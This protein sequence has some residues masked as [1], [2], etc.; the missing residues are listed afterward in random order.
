[1]IGQTF[2]APVALALA[3]AIACTSPRETEARREFVRSFVMSV[4]EGSEFYR[5]HLLQAH[6]LE[7]EKARFQMSSSFEIVHEDVTSM[8]EWPASGF[9]YYLRFSNGASGVLWLQEK[10]S[11]RRAGLRV[12][13]Y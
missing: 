1:M 9:E 6:A 7:T 8:A 3:L 10:G 11:Q 5:D 2:R 12:Q 4:Y 13:Q